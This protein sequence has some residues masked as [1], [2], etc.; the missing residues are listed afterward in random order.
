MPK[1]EA[2]DQRGRL[3]CVSR[4]RRLLSYDGQPGRNSVF[5]PQPLRL[6]RQRSRV[7]RNQK[8]LGD[9][10]ANHTFS[11]NR[12]ELDRRILEALAWI[13]RTVLLGGRDLLT[14]V[15]WCRPRKAMK[16]PPKPIRA[17]AVATVTLAPAVLRPLHP[18]CF[19]RQAGKSPASASCGSA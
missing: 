10:T 17:T 19:G 6:R 9:R 5:S 7:P 2:A 1:K 11:H 14:G 16:A 3:H 13:E 8:D 12:D 18:G 15:R 4:S